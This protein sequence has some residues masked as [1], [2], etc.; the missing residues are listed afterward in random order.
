MVSVIVAIAPLLLLTVLPTFLN[1]PARYIVAGQNTALFLGLFP[2]ALGYS[3]LRYQLLVLDA[4]VRRAVSWI[5]GI[6]GL[7]MLFYVAAAISELVFPGGGPFYALS[8]AAMMAAL[9]PLVWWLAHVTT[10]RFFFSEIAHYRRII[11]QPSLLDDEVL[12]LEEA[13]RLFTV[14]AVHTFETS[15]ACLFVLDESMGHYLLYPPLKAEAEIDP[16][17]ALVHEVREALG[18]DPDSTWLDLH[19]PAGERLMKSRR[20]LLLWEMTRPPGKAPTGLDRFLVPSQP[21]PGEHVL[22]APVRAQGKVIALLVLGARGD[23]EPYAGPDFGIVQLL[24]SRFSQTLENAR[25]YARAGQYA[26]LLEQLNSASAAFGSV[27]HSI[28]KVASVYARAASAATK[29]GAEIWLYHEQEQTLCRVAASG[30]VPRISHEEILHSTASLDW[31]AWFRDTQQEQEEMAPPCLQPVPACSFAWLPLFKNERR[32]GIFVLTYAF[33]HTFLKD[34]EHV[35][36]IFASQCADALESARLAAELQASYERQKELDRL[37][38]Q[39]IMNVSH[40]LRTPL[41]AIQGYIELLRQHHETL[42]PE[43]QQSFIAKAS[44]GCEELA[45][46]VNNIMD[47]SRVQIDVQEVALAEHQLQALVLHA[48][49]ILDAL[50]KHEAHEIVLSIPDDCCVLV[51]PSRLNQVLLNLLS[52]AL[53][54]S[55][56]ATKIELNAQISDTQVTVRVRDYGLGVPPPE[57]SYLFERF[58]RLERDMSGAV[59]GVGLGLYICRQLVQAMGGHIWVE[60]SGRPGEGSTFAFTLKRAHPT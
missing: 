38:D 1:L 53:K 24:L 59:R 42:S 36:E 21:L 5:M 20:P 6:I 30:P 11:E 27:A 12:D 9:S 23:G 48:V 54:Y 2:L 17:T 13:A 57:Q 55:P 15:Q 58:I 31:M 43:M 25:L 26:V 32:V 37:K 16:R 35:L 44:L 52:N 49:E 60:S 40:E 3:I 46:M 4:H 18:Q 51:D 33:P 19:L 41:T 34:E 22:L 47:A 50:I 10:E 7:A 14:A 8:I 28:E 39:F 45:L 56:H 29:A